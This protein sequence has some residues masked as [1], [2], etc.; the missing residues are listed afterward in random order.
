MSVR[1]PVRISGLGWSAWW[2]SMPSPSPGRVG[3]T[4]PQS[5]GGQTLGILQKGQI[6]LGRSRDPPGTPWET[7]SPTTKGKNDQSRGSF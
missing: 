6:H 3:L 5:E 7:H 2:L 1:P 4:G